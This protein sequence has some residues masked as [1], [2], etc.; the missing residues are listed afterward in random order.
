MK[1]LGIDYGKKRLG[2]ALYDPTVRVVVPFGLKELADDLWKDLPL[3]VS[4]EQVE[5]IIVGLPLSLAGQENEQTRTVRVFGEKL[6][7]H[8]GV[9]VEFFDE[10]FTSVAAD[11]FDV[12]ISRDEKAA[13]LILEG[14]VEQRAHQGI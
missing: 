6:T 13:V 2:L 14:W 1:I 8:V 12:G 10:R 7:K 3:I 9:P 11:Q 4:R 5:R